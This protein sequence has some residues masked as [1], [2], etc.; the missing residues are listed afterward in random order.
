MAIIINEKCHYLI[1]PGWKGS[2]SDH[3]QS[4][5]QA[6]LPQASRI[7][8]TDWDLPRFDDWI[9]AIERAV[10]RLEGP[11]VLIAHSLGCISIAHWTT[12]SA[13]TYK[14]AAA[15]L[16]APA[17]VEQGP[18]RRNL[19]AFAPIPG[20]PLP[21]TSLVVGSTNDWS[22]SRQRIEHFANAWGSICHI[23]ANV[24]HINVESGHS[25]WPEGLY[26]LSHLTRE[27]A[28]ETP[29]THYC[30]DQ[31]SRFRTARSVGSAAAR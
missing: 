22:A 16:V 17:D 9:E 27:I 12:R 8:V 1:V 4:H 18:A 11:I 21:F 3:W 29:G 28:P 31:H 2:G 26:L 30:E 13:F 25:H 23:I 14:I 5:W 10:S 15:M 19:K 24:G 20:T 6:V 7:Q